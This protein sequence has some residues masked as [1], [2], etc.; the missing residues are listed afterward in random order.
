MLHERAGMRGV[1]GVYLEV[2]QDFMSG[3]RA[4]MRGVSGVYLPFVISEKWEKCK[5]EKC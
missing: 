2:G 4:G 5:K 1:S 3:F